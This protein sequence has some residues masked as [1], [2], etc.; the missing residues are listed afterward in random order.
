MVI[1]LREQNNMA[2]AQEYDNLNPFHITQVQAITYF[3]LIPYVFVKTWS[4]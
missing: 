2:T 1:F 3:S 4:A